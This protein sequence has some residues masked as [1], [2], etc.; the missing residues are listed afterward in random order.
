MDFYR[1]K[2]KKLLQFYHELLVFLDEPSKET[3]PEEQQGFLTPEDLYQHGWQFYVRVCK[4]PPFPPW[5]E[6]EVYR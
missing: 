4:N 5:L 3:T 2:E 6:Y 1:N